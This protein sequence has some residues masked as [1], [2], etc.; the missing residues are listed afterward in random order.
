VSVSDLEQC[1]SES[2]EHRH[3]EESDA[4]RP[5]LFMTRM[6]R[7][8]SSAMLDDHAAE[9]SSSRLQRVQRLFIKTEQREGTTREESTAQLRHGVHMHLCRA[10]E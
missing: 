4:T 6:V 9:R 7:R 1:I 8:T 10:L 5:C 3:D 2:C